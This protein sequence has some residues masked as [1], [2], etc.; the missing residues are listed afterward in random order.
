M[1]L[2]GFC[3][4]AIP[5]SFEKCGDVYLLDNANAGILDE[6]ELKGLLNKNVIMDSEAFGIVNSRLK[7]FDIK[8]EKWIPT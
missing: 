8:V 1:K 3:R 2:N 6:E 5:V 4:T 7:A